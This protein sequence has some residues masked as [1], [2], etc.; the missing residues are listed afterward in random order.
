MA[1]GLLGLTEE[2]MVLDDSIVDQGAA[3]ATDMGVGVPLRGLAMGGPTGVGDAEFAGQ[4]VL[5][6]GIGE[7]LDLAE[8]ADAAKLARSGQD[9]HPR[10]IIASV[11][12]PAQSLQENGR[13]VPLSNAAHYA[14]HGYCPLGPDYLGILTGRVQ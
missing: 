14:T 13:Y 11:F 2:S 9:R 10:G 3:V 1:I 12:Q 7:A 5:V 4:R 6:H 8:G